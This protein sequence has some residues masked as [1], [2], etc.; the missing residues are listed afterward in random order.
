MDVG[1][2][3]STEWAGNTTTV[4]INY[5]CDITLSNEGKIQSIIYDD[6][7]KKFVVDYASKAVCHYSPFFTD[8]ISMILCYSKSLVTDVE[9]NGL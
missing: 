1:D 3:I 7:K 4:T 9:Y 6:Q 2:A 5:R 8:N